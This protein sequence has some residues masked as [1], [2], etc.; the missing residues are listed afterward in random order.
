MEGLVVLVL[1]IAATGLLGIL[2]VMFGV[3]SRDGST[4][5]RS[6]ERGLTL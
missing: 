3:D 4:D 2:S 6:P 5:P 1:V